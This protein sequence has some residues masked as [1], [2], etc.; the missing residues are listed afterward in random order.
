MNTETFTAEETFAFGKK[1]GENAKNG[2]V[3]TLSGEL[4]VGK[5]V[6]AKGFAVGLGIDESVTSPTFTIINEYT[7]GKI[8]FYHFDIYRISDPDELYETGFEEYFYG[9]GVCLVEWAEL[10]GDLIP[11]NAKKITISKNIEKGEDYRNIEVKEL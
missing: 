7:S 8:P 5:T 1:L 4:G 9:D 10:A 2:E 6:F 3:Y 11:A